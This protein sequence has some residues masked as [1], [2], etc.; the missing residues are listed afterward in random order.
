M[1]SRAVATLADLVPGYEFKR[2]RSVPRFSPRPAGGCVQRLKVPRK[3]PEDTRPYQ[4]GDPVHMIDWRAFGRTDQLLLRQ[5]K[6]P[7]PVPV[8]IQV[9]FRDSTYWDQ[10][11]AETT[12]RLVLFCAFG[13]LRRG[14]QVEIQLVLDG[15]PDRVRRF[16]GTRMVQEVFNWLAAD[17]FSW[18]PKNDDSSPFLLPESTQPSR[19]PRR[20]VISDDLA[21]HRHES[22][23]SGLAPGDLMLHVLAVREVTDDWRHVQA[24]YACEERDDDEWE[25]SW[26]AQNI[27]SAREEWFRDL[28]RRATLG[29]ATSLRVTPDTP[30]EEFITFFESWC[31]A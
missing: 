3:F 10:A 8:R 16:S 12:W 27:E 26:L 7:A 15:V 5:Q 6:D 2:S 18:K 29:G 28:D 14:D 23:F 4:A 11:K 9:H 30:V 13:L 31:G 20:V 24:V 1:P 22:D 21:G 25:G 17:G 19:K